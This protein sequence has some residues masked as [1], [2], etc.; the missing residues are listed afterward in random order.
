MDTDPRKTQEAASAVKDDAYHFITNWRLQATC[1]EVYRILEEVERLPEWWPSV[2]LD[3]KVLEKGQPGGVGKCV[4]LYTKGW[5][6][7]TLRWEFIVTSATF[8]TGFS[9]R[10]IGDFAGTG[11]WHFEQNDE[12]CH[13]SYDWKISAEKP[14]L[15]KL[16]WL[17]RPVFSANH[18]WAMRKGLES[19]QLELLRRRGVPQVPTPPGPT[20]P[21]NILNNK[22]L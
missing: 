19:L 6:P 1:E 15:K 8:P 13:V 20:F 18:E 7:Y 5:L 11:I 14:L 3:V 4:A 2:Y 17:L 21:H 22:V 9:L 12:T 10:A 16:S